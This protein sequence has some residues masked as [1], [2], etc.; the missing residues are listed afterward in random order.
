V[1]KVEMEIRVSIRSQY[2]TI[3][4]KGKIKTDVFLRSI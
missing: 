1:E 2:S 3:N 4:F